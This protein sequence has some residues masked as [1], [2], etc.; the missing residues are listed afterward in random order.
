MTEEYR[1]KE[2]EFM[3]RTDSLCENTPIHLCDCSK[4]PTHDLCKW[5]CD[6]DPTVSGGD[7]NGRC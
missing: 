4:C 3:E 2:L 6:N 7:N 5:L 1:R